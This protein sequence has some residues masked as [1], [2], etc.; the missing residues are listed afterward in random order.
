MKACSGT[1]TDTWDPC[2]EIQQRERHLHAADRHRRTR[3]TPTSPSSRSGSVS[4]GPAQIARVARH[5]PGRRQAAR[6]QLKSFTLGTNEVSPLSMAEAYAT[7]A[8]RGTHCNS[9]AILEVTDPSRQPARRCPQA[10]CQQVLDQNIADGMNELL[11]GVMTRGTGARA[12]I[13]A[14]GRRQDRHHRQ[15][16]I[17]GLVRRLHARPRDGRVGRQPAAR[18]QV[19]T[20]CSNRLDRRRLLRRR[21]RWLPARADLAADDEPA[22]WRAP[23]SA[24]SPTPPTTSA[25]ATPITCRRSPACRS[26]R[27]RQLLRAARLDPVVSGNTGLRRLRARPARSPTPHPGGGSSVVPGPARHRSTSSAGAVP[28]PPSQTT[29]E[30]ARRHRSSTPSGPRR[31]TGPAP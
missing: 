23:R 18:P 30:P 11:Q 16:R 31:P 24:R 21:L 28:E 14:A 7:F 9:I 8:A 2:N 5:D 19:A 6:Q 27:P 26:T 25:T 29:P 15:P 13:G 22:P 3:S 20:R 4:A 1:L 12:A 17:S 10:D